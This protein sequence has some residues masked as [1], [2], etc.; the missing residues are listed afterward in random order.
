VLKLSQALNGWAPAQPQT[1][2]EPI[3]LLEAGWQ[4]IVGAEVAMNSHPAG[5]TAGT[6]TIVTRSSAWSNQ[7]AFL[8]EHV[9]GA[10][11]ARLPGAGVERLRCRVGRIAPRVRPSVAPRGVVPARAARRATR[12]PSASAPEALARFRRD[13]E[14]DR[15][16][17]S[18]RGWKECSGCGT[19]I[20]PAAGVAC[21]PCAALEEERRGAATARLL[22]EAP[23]LGY[24]G[25]AALVDGLREG[26]YERIRSRMLRHWWR[27]L[28]QARIAKRISLDGRERAVAS[29]YV[30]LQSRLAPEQIIPETVASILG[31]ELM[32]LLYG[33]S[34]HGGAEAKKKRKA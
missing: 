17:R 13:V 19:L 25:T 27:M 15:R 14:N 28:A 10:V 12:D 11:A 26:E 5:I 30:L 22:F 29:S 24:A 3:A 34:R 8:A 32:E 4:Q 31:N 9:V 6:L 2:P 7:L 18:A 16:N 21:P 33:D 20:E 1:P 23:W